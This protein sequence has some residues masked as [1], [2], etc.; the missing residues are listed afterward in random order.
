VFVVGVVTGGVQWLVSRHDPPRPEGHVAVANAVHVLLGVVVL[1]ALVVA[2]R[3]HR[4]TLLGFAA[5]PFRLDG[6]RSLLLATA[7]IPLALWR[8]LGAVAR[9]RVGKQHFVGLPVAFVLCLAAV[10]IWY[11]PFRDGV[12]VLAGLDR[13]FTRD[14]WGGPSYLGAALAHWLD[15]ALIFYAAF[16][17]VRLLTAGAQRREGVEPAPD[18]PSLE[19]VRSGNS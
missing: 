11:T 2:A 19:R 7:A 8:L 5:W 12:Q 16:A 6:W 9:G 4:A 10:N 17:V 13:N 1:V 3:S 18:G 15:G 14:A